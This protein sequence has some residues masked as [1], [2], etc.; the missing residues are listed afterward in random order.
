MRKEGGMKKAREASHAGT[1]YSSNPRDL[2]HFFREC[3]DKAKKQSTDNEEETEEEEKKKKKKSG[4]VFA[5]ICPHAGYSYCGQTAAYA[6]AKIHRPNANIRRV[7]VLGPSHY[8]YLTACALPSSSLDSYLTPYGKIPLD[9]QV[10]KSLREKS[11]EEEGEEGGRGLFFETLSIEDDE[12]EHSIEMQLPFLHYI[13][14]QNSAKFTLVPIVVGDLRPS[15][16]RRLARLLLPY[17]SSEENFFV[18]SSDFCHWGKRFR[19]T[20]LPSSSSSGEGTNDHE[21]VRPIYERIE[22]LD[23]EAAS[24][25]V[26]KDTQD[27]ACNL[28]YDTSTCIS[29]CVYTS[30]AMLSTYTTYKERRAK[31]HPALAFF[32]QSMLSESSSSSS[33][34]LDFAV[35]FL[36]YS[37][38]SQVVDASSSSV[39]YAAFSAT[40]S[41][42]KSNEN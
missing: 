36:H 18:F 22:I 11:E 15:S 7:F 21:E 3:L 5:L 28:K 26:K 32:S 19:Y 35:E 9:Q 39:S 33:S 29:T 2:D 30:I 25:I 42:S 41:Q 27:S 24:L 13:L 38:S 31:K 6:W 20:Y 10:M 23:K 40:L 37:Q 4:R 1:W 16:H 14:L 12:A 34:S 17:L 8:V